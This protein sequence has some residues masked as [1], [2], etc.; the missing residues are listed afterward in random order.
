MTN[1]LR[2]KD[3]RCPIVC[4]KK[5]SLIVVFIYRPNEGMPII[6][7]LCLHGGNIPQYLRQ[8][9]P[10]S[11]RVIVIS[12]RNDSIARGCAPRPVTSTGWTWWG[13]HSL[14]GFL[15]CVSCCNLVFYATD[16]GFRTGQRSRLQAANNSLY[17]RRSRI[18]PSSH[19][20][21][22]HGDPLLSISFSCSNTA[23]ST[24]TVLAGKHSTVCRRGGKYG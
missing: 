14:H 7:T 6:C 23:D 19:L 9:L 1:N 2:R 22:F 15:L 3:N 10:V 5:G 8:T 20:K 11:R 13:F 21:I 4:F 12:L 17:D 24:R 16:S 18:I